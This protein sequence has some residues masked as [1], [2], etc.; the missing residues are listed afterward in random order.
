[1]SVDTESELKEYFEELIE[2]VDDP[3]HK[4]ILQAS[5][6]TANPLIAMEKELSKYLTGL[7]RFLAKGHKI[8]V[9]EAQNQSPTRRPWVPHRHPRSSQGAATEV[10]RDRG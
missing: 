7:W 4:R 3:L 6:D 2:I 10:F 1:M 8:M 9:I 5:R